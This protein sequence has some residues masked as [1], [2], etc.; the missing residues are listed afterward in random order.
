MPSS[1]N[2]NDITLVTPVA[3]VM[4][5]MVMVMIVVVVMVS[6][7]VNVLVSGFIVA[8]VTALVYDDIRLLIVIVG[9]AC[10][11]TLVD[12]FGLITVTVALDDHFVHTV[13]G[14]VGVALGVIVIMVMVIVMIVVVVL[15]VILVMIIMAFLY[16]YIVLMRSTCIDVDQIPELRWLV[17]G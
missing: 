4:V 8:P 11:H 5:I 1:V 17:K 15:A 9:V 6:R 14:V 16:D 10:Q 7:L 13:L 12:D 2:D 3:I